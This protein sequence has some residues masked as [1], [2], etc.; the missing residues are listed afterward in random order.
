VDGNEFFQTVR[1][2]M[3]FPEAAERLPIPQDLV[4]RLV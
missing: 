4:E 2:E 3:G 1:K